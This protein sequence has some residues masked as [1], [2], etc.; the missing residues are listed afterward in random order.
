M[1][2]GLMGFA[3]FSKP[4]KDMNLLNALFSISLGLFLGGMYRLFLLLFFRLLNKDLKEKYERKAVK[5]AAENG[6]V[7]SFPSQ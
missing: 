1:G 2:F 3:A 6:L 5:K 4:F 7:T